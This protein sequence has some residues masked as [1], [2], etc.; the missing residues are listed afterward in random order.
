M[1]SIAEIDNQF[2][3]KENHICTGVLITRKFV[4]TAAH[5][6]DGRLLH[7]IRIIVGSVDLRQGK[8][9][10]ITMWITYYQWAKSK[11]ITKINELNDIAI[12]KV[13]KLFS[14]VLPK[15]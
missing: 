15:F 11:N 2:D 5:C 4:L 6:F 9:H 10:D 13:K 1:V 7:R 3:E 8:K 14:S 12:V